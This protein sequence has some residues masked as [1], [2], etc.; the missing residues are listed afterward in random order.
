MK[1]NIKA[2]KNRPSPITRTKIELLN[3]ELEIIDPKIA[4]RAFFPY[5]FVLQFFIE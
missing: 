1:N 3:N 2:A 4:S 5:S